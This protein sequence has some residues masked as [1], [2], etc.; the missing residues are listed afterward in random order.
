MYVKGVDK[1]LGSSK[2][3]QPIQ[4]TKKSGIQNTKPPLK[5]TTE[6]KPLGRE[7]KKKVKYS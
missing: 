6:S 2:G 4:G 7:K 3:Q 1:L 5:T